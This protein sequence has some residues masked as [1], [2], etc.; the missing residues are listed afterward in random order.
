M[1]DVEMSKFPRKESLWAIFAGELNPN[2]ITKEISKTITFF[3]LDRL[4]IQVTLFCTKA[5]Y[6]PSR[7]EGCGP[8]N[9]A[10][11]RPQKPYVQLLTIITK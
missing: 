8:A 3:S 11:V 10:L 7:K 2:T 5:S 4:H 6:F 9:L 1:K